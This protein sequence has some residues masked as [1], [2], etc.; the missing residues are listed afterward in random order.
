MKYHL[1]PLDYYNF[2]DLVGQI[3]KDSPHTGVDG[4]VHGERDDA[5]VHFFSHPKAEQG[6][7]EI[8]PLFRKIFTIKTDKTRVGVRHIIVR[9][10]GWVYRGKP[11]G[12]IFV[13]F[14]T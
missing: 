7:I 14:V 8:S 11:S 3:S 13:Y 1:P 6:I 10:G 9:E 2:F 4:V 5:E 12:F